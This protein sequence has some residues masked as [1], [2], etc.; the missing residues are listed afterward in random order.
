MIPL[1]NF[2]AHAARTKTKNHTMCY[3]SNLYRIRVSAHVAL[4]APIFKTFYLIKRKKKK[5]QKASKYGHLESVLEAGRK[6]HNHP[7]PLGQKFKKGL[8]HSKQNIVL[9]LQCWTKSLLFQ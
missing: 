5:Q 8:S 9:G 4:A 2:A 7:K 1:A 6:P 3:A